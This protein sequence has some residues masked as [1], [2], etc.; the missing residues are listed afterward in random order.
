[1]VY[2]GILKALNE[3]HGIEKLREWKVVKIECR[4]S[5]KIS[6]HES[7]LAYVDNSGKV[8]FLLFERAGGDPAHQSAPDLL[9]P[10]LNRSVTSISSVS[11]SICPELRAQDM[12]S[13]LGSGKL[14]DDEIVVGTLTFPHG[15]LSVL[16]LAL[17]AGEVHT[18]SPSYLLL[19]K[20]CY[21]FVSTM[22]AV[23]TEA[24]SG[25][26]DMTPSAG[27]WCG[28]NLPSARSED[29]SGLCASLKKQI[30]TFVSCVSCLVTNY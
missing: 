6:G 25:E 27:K 13:P 15:S 24:Y 23:L 9:Q 22:L 18:K 19:S 21:H 7:M 20:N 10:S 28:L 12:V 30:G 4:K 8:Y 3:I 1:M 29:V 17:L 26:L 16:D 11:D 14:S 2:I 5:K